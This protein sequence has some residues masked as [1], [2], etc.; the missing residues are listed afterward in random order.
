MQQRR[1]HFKLLRSLLL[2]LL[3][4]TL[5]TG[6]SSA[7]N[8]TVHY[9]SQRYDSVVGNWRSSKG[10]TMGLNEDGTFWR[11]GTG[12][13]ER[14]TYKVQQEQ[15]LQIGDSY[16]PYPC[17]SL[18]K[19]WSTDTY[20][21]RLSGS[22]L[23]MC[24][25]VAKDGSFPANRTIVYTRQIDDS[26]AGKT[27]TIKVSDGKSKSPEEAVVKYYQYTL[28]LD[29]DKAL[30]GTQFCEEITSH[31][32]ASTNAE[33]FYAD[34]YS[35]IQEE[36]QNDYGGDVK[37]YIKHLWTYSGMEMKRVFNESKANGKKPVPKDKV[38]IEFVTVQSPINDTEWLNMLQHWFAGTD[39][40][41][42][43][44]AYVECNVI[45]E[46]T[47]K[48]STQKNRL[49]QHKGGWYVFDTTSWDYY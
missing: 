25:S 34:L 6:C 18:Q 35:P 30:Q 41:W 37:K 48:T 24:D 47:G 33:R 46:Q 27:A 45:N 42:E 17:I 2:I 15:W 29:A 9:S 23:E 7:K 14:G 49:I 19:D 31:L 43:N 20:F 44:T 10:D 5:I 28:A 40:S 26:A 4:T 8:H 16:K 3:C 12:Y 1:T 36:I 39:V 38:R 13:S 32:L 11:N 22:T 21:Y